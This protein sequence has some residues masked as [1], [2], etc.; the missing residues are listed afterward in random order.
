MQYLSDHHPSYDEYG[1]RSSH[2]L[3]LL[4][5]Y[6]IYLSS[7]DG[8]KESQSSPQDLCSEWKSNL[9]K[10]N[11]LSVF[12]AA[13]AL[14]GVDPF[15]D[16][17][18]FERF[19]INEVVYER[20]RAL[21]DEAIDDGLINTFEKTNGNYTKTFLNA[22]DFAAWCD[23]IGIARPL[24]W[25]YERTVSTPTTVSTLAGRIVA[26][27]ISGGQFSASGIHQGKFADLP[28]QHELTELR[29]K[30]AEANEKLLSLER[31]N[32]DL[33]TELLELEAQKGGSDE[34]AIAKL[35]AENEQLRAEALYSKPVLDNGLHFRY[36]TPLLKLIAE[37]QERY[38]G[39]L[40]SQD[41]PDT[42]TKKEVIANWL[43]KEKGVSAVRA[44]QMAAI[45]V[46]YNKAPR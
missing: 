39:E 11:R 27:A 45:A 40:F 38:C 18:T 13:C 33:T 34:K 17:E 42:W 24:P 8:K 12:E 9:A 28:P 10:R 37:I 16:E 20:G 15:S 7:E 46:P 5:K 29:K 1:F 41:D 22:R 6:G 14:A 21:L 32:Y 31:R 2:I 36:V 35:R 26:N 30:L 23:S 3:P 43:K 25:R 19:G 44:E 4:E